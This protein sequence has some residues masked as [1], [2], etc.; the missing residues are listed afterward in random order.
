MHE[1]TMLSRHNNIL[2]AMVRCDNRFIDPVHCVMNYVVTFGLEY[3]VQF[4]KSP[5][6]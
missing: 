1:I 2:S 3:N 6:V 5:N 4:L